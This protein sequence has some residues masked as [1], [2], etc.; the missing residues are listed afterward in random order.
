MKRRAVLRFTFAPVVEAGSGDVGVPEPFLDLGDVRLVR[1]GVRRRHCPQRM[2][3]QPVY[4]G[5]DP[6]V[7]TVFADDVAIDGAGLQMLFQGARCGC[8]SRGSCQVSS[9]AMA[10]LLSIIAVLKPLLVPTEFANLNRYPASRRGGSL[11]R[12][13]R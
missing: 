6:S 4:F 9:P 5:I 12:K 13:G 11:P 7:M 8:F 2:H 1:E 10:S 3:T